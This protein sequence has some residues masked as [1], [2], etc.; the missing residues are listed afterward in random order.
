M[1]Q[2]ADVKR[3]M[4]LTVYLDDRPG[5]LGSLADLLGRNNVNIFGLAAAGTA[6]GHGYARLVVDDTEKARQLIE[7]ANELV[8]ADEVLLLR[9]DNRS[10]ELARVLQRLA[11]AQL[12]IEY[13][14]SVGGP[15]EGKAIV[16]RP[17]DIDT[18]LAALG[19]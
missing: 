1:E 4:Q 10:G 7:D 9:A 14:Y 19:A 11:G 13:A 18:A 6:E 3:G 2:P 8:A 12:N 16:L 15:G 17:S 5:T